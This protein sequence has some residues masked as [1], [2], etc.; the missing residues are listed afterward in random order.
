MGSNP[1]RGMTVCVCLFCICVVLFLVAALQLDQLESKDPYRL[2][3]GV[4]N[5]NCGQGTTVGYRVIIIVIIIM[6]KI[7]LFSQGY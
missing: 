5:G 4:R 1:T 3:I 2:Y 6:K 7:I